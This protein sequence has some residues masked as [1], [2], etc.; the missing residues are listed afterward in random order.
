MSPPA[1]VF[2]ENG[3][4]PE[5]LDEV[6]EELASKLGMDRSVLGL[7]DPPSAGDEPPPVE[8]ADVPAPDVAGEDTGVGDPGSDPA[9]APEPPVGEEIAEGASERQPLAPS[10]VD[11]E[12]EP[13]APVAVDEEPVE[14]P[15]P[16]PEP[17]PEPEP[18]DW[19]RTGAYF[20]QVY[21]ER[22]TIE[23][24]E[25]Q[26]QWIA[27]ASPIM[28]RLSQAPPDQQEI[29]M[30]IVEGRF[31]PSTLAPQPPPRPVDPADALYGDPQPAPAQQSDPQV[32]NELR[33][34]REQQEQSANQQRQQQVVADVSKALQQFQAENPQV[35]ADGIRALA[36]SVN[37]NGAWIRQAEAGVPVTDAYLRHLRGHAALSDLPLGRPAAAAPAP[38]APAPSE[39]VEQAP[40]DDGAVDEAE[41]RQARSGAIAGAS[42]PAAAPRRRRSPLERPDAAAPDR[43]A[44]TDEN[45]AEKL[46]GALQEMGIE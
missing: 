22:P 7:D 20:E 43:E 11:T 19:D 28:E 8:P 9:A 37:E 29:V 46:A 13:E 30:A 2:D 42:A 4:T 1:D 39:P 34:L 26:A 18:S 17:Q 24:F 5:A 25:Q 12:P 45:L 41:E 38:A 31:D 44:I 15:A 27:Q 36:R 16:E 32:V 40:L 10:A 14:A 23:Q 33:R 35:D 3:L 21:G 6:A